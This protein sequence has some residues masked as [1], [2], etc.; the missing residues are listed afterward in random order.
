MEW[1]PIDTA[2]K[3]FAILLYRPTA[4]P[5]SRIAVGQW[6]EDRFAKHPR[7]FWEMLSRIVSRL[8]ERKWR[9]THWMLLPDPPR[10]TDEPNKELTP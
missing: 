10:P 4:H 7:P 1:Q 5:W 2:P 3:G 8:E 6:N 9:P